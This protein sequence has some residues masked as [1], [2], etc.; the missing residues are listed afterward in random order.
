MAIETESYIC[1]MASSQNGNSTEFRLRAKRILLT[2]SQVGPLFDHQ[3]I[4]QLIGR[5]GAR[6]VLCRERHRDGGIHYHALLLFDSAYNT[7][8]HTAFDVGGAHPNIK[9]IRWTPRK[10]YDYVRKDGDVL[11][12]NLSDDDIDGTGS[13]SRSAWSDI[14]AAPDKLAF[15]KAV[16]DLD[17]RALACSFASIEKY[18]EWAYREE[19]SEYESPISW[20]DFD[21]TEFPELQGWYTQNVA[22]RGSG[23]RGAHSRVVQRPPRGAILSANTY[24]IQEEITSSVG[25]NPNGQDIAGEVPGDSL[26]LRRAIQLRSILSPRRLRNLR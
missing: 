24:F 21:V 13:N 19:Q 5:L 12:C 20:S 1:L 4:T 15:F 16:R 2:Y 22:I 18:A 14:I 8:D 23:G 6:G 11:F 3:Q 10:A 17:P 9:P 7:R 26:I 25:A